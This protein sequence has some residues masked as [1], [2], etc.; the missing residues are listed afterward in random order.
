NGMIQRWAIADQITSKNS[1]VLL[2]NDQ[3]L[4]SWWLKSQRS[5]NM[6]QQA[7]R[8]LGRMMLGSALSGNTLQA[9]VDYAN[10]PEVLG[11][12]SAFSNTDLLK[13]G[14]RRLVGAI[15]ATPEFQVR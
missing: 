2:D 1:G 13:A 10:S 4:F 7:A 14:L 12:S 15:A 3:S 9:L 5:L 11:G 6:P 8:L